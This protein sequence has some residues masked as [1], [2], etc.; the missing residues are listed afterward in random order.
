MKHFF[1]PMLLATL[2][3][4]SSV[5]AYAFTDADEYGSAAT[6][7]F[8]NRTIIIDSHTR[9]INVMHGETVTISNGQNSVTW[10]FDGIGSAFELSKIMPAAS[11]AVEVYVAPE[12]I[13]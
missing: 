5:A 4:G 9:Y 6:A 2:L 7:G 11:Q 8:A 12:L 1:A 13:G 10:H 3:A